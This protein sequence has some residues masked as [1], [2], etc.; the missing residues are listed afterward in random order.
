MGL[1]LDETTLR[2]L[3][4]AAKVLTMNRSE[5]VRY[6]ILH[7]LD[8]SNALRTRLKLGFAESTHANDGG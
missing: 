5:F 4:E 7:V 6:C 8:E 3:S 1:Y 2:L